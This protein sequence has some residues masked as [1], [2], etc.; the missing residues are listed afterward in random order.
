LNALIEMCIQMKALK[1]KE[2]ELSKIT[3]Q[4]DKLANEVSN[5]RTVVDEQ[6]KQRTTL[7]RKM[8][9]DNA[10]FQTEKDKLKFSE[11]LSFIIA[12]PRVIL[13]MIWSIQIV[14]K[15]VH[16]C[17]HGC[18][19]SKQASRDTCS[20]VAQQAWQP[21][22]KQGEGLEGTARCDGKTE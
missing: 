6:K 14:T 2:S 7:Q 20:A 13:R 1:S 17:I 9:E 12:S 5:M 21:T 10:T 4:K 8:R 16:I 3:T 22:A 19:D 15:M 18:S 11:V